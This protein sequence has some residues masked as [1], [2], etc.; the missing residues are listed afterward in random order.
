MRN[1]TLVFA[2]LATSALLAACGSGGPARPQVKQI[3]YSDGTRVMMTYTG[4]LLA[5]VKTVNKDGAVDSDATVAY[6][7]GRLTTFSVGAPGKVPTA[8]AYIYDEQGRLSRISANTTNSAY[9]YT[10]TYSQGLISRTD[11]SLVGGGVTTTVATTYTFDTATQKLQQTQ[12][13]TNMVVFGI[14]VNSL[15]TSIYTYDVSTN[16]LKT[17]QVT[18]GDSSTLYDFSYDTSSRL[19]KVVGGGSTYTLEYGTDGYISRSNYTNNGNASFKSYT[20]QSGTV[21]GVLANPLIQFGDLFDMGG[22]ELPY[23]QV[24]VSSSLMG[25]GG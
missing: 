13:T 12:T 15:T 18:G 21:T 10:A 1:P 16:L 17:V 25:L 6:V 22:R 7:A 14:P 5:T 4:D 24:Y 20:Y 8:Y 19:S 2:S 23:D 3:D 9:T 11:L